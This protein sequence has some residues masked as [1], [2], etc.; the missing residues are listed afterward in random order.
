MRQTVFEKLMLL[1][2]AA[3]LLGLV[4]S[5]KQRIDNNHNLKAKWK[6]GN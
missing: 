6:Q 3:A 5:V 1:L 4:W 2:A